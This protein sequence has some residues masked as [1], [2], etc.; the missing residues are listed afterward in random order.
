MKNLQAFIEA[1]ELLI[2]QI[3]TEGL[4]SYLSLRPEIKTKLIATPWETKE[5]LY[6]M[7]PRLRYL[8]E[9]TEPH[10][11][12][13]R[14]GKVLCFTTSSGKKV[15]TRRVEHPGTKPRPV[16]SEIQAQKEPIIMQKLEALLE[17]FLGGK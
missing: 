13:P 9:G 14:N 5:T 17:R 16:L 8:E 10:T 6:N 1:A 11:I 2:R 3:Y 4:S 7:V 15:F 12:E